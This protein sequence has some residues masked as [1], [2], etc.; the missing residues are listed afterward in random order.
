MQRADF[1]G[2]DPGCWEIWKAKGEEGG[3]G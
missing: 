2:K 1:F 3:K